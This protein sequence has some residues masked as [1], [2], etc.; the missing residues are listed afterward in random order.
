M[1][2]LDKREVA[3]R[4]QGPFQ[5]ESILESPSLRKTFVKL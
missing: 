4:M 2:S 5:V 3:K 1:D